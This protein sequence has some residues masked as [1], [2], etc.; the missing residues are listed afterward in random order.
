[1]AES[2]LEVLVTYAAEAS[3]AQKELKAEADLI[4][5]FVLEY[6]KAN[7]QKTF[8]YVRG[9]AQIGASSHS[10]YGTAT[11]L[12]RILKKLK[13]MDIFDTLV[14][15]KIGE[16]KKYIGEAVLLEEKFIKVKTE[17]YGKVTLK[18]KM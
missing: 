8:D 11:A 5:K 18:S 14:S 17:P 16:V 12:A 4:K 2:E 9:S 10:E 13:K 15:V 3:A 6:A 7:Q 1:M